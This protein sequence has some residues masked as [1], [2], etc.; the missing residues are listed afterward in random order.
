MLGEVEYERV[1]YETQSEEGIKG[2]V[3]LLDEAMGISGSGFMSG[4]LSEQIVQASCEN[5]YR[6]AARSV[7][8]M[9]GQ[10]I[11]HTAAWHVIQQFGDR[12]NTQE[13]RAAK[14][15]ATHKGKGK[16]ET[17]L[18]FEEQ[19]GIYLN[20]QGADRKREG[21]G[22][23]MKLAV[24]YDGA[25][26]VGK[27]RYELTH[28]VACANFERI[29]SFVRRKEGVIADTYNTDEIE[30]RFLNGDGAA[31]IK[32]SVCDDMV[33][34]QLDVF[35]RN[36]AIRQWVKDAEKQKLI[37]ELLYSKRIDD[38]LGCIEGYINCLD[39]TVEEE[40]IEKENLNSLL[41]YFTS[42]KDGLVPCHRRGLKLPQPP[43][44]VEYRRMGAME[45]NIFTVLG[46]RMKGGRACWSIKGGNNLAR[47]LCLKATKKLSHT[48]QSL[49][50]TV[51]S[52]RY[53]EATI[54]FLSST[55]IAKSVGEGYNGF[56]KA[57]LSDAPE[58]Q[59]FRE[60]FG[61]TPFSS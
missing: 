31:W 27:D 55:K 33:H 28:K 7:S 5:S 25:K 57:S 54:T 36:R 14:L 17:K 56:M 42:N 29:Q 32:R 22:K 13:E 50:S 58:L 59:A 12:I 51:L 9:T 15:A 48:L 30:M 3:Y 41:T 2:C 37:F 24:A 43:E 11:S 34:F 46:N 39:D 60:K 49:T 23:E 10:S 4:L 1:V 18:L 16:L 19:D 53:A 47:L 20:L 26:K 35:H 61:L 44:G 21:K 38:L 8:E 45:S 6:G 40:A 52:E